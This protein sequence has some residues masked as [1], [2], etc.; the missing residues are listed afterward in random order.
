MP[1][2]LGLVT[3]GPSVMTCLGMPP[4]PVFSPDYFGTLDFGFYFPVGVAVPVPFDFEYFDLT[5]DANFGYTITDE[6]IFSGDHH[7]YD[8]NIGGVVAFPF[9]MSLNMR[10]VDTTVNDLRDAG[11]R[12]VIGASYAF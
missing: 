1:S 7:Y 10:Y 12:F 5:L 2:A 11:A 8:W 3:T 4:G 6:I 9:N